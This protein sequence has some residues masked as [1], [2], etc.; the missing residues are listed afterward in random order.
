MVKYCV[1]CENSK[2][3]H[4]FFLILPDA[5]IEGIEY[6]YEYSVLMSAGLTQSSQNKVKTEINCILAASVAE[7]FSIQVQVRLGYD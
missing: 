2:I 1:L 6:E 7:E 3:I 5:L 4:C